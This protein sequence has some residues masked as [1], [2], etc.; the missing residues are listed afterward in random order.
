MKTRS[1]LRSLLVPAAV[2]LLS[3]SVAWAGAGL[4]PVPTLPADP[5]EVPDVNVDDPAT[6]LA[7]ALAGAAATT[8]PETTPF[9]A[10]GQTAMPTTSLADGWYHVGAA[11]VNLYPRPDEYGGVWNRDADACAT[12]DQDAFT[13]VA[14]ELAGGHDGHDHNDHVVTS[15]PWPENP[16]CLYMGGFGIGP[17]NPI[18]EFDDEYGLWV[19]TVV[20]STG[21]DDDGDGATDASVLTVIDAEGWLYDYGSKCD[22]C[23]WKQI[24]ARLADELGVSTSAFV[25]HATHSHASMDFL[26]GWGFVPDWYMQQATDSIEESVRRAVAA[27]EPA[28]IEVGEVLARGQNRERRDTYHAAEDP[29]LSFVRAYVPA[30]T[31]VVPGPAPDDEPV[32][33]KG[34]DYR[35]KAA[36]YYAEGDTEK[37]DKYTAKADEKDAKYGC[38]RADSHEVVVPARTIATIGGYAAHPT[39]KGTNGGVAHPDWP[40]LFAAGAEARFGGMAMHM[41]SGLGNMSSRGGTQIG[42]T[43]AAALPNVGAGDLL[44]ASS[45]RTAETTWAQPATN[46][47]LTGLGLPGFFDRNFLTEPA[48]IQVS[49][50][51]GAKNVAVDPAWLAGQS[52]EGGT[53]SCFSVSPFSVE[54]VARAQNIGGLLAITSGPGEMFSNSTNT[55]EEKALERGAYALAVAQANDSLGYLP[56]SFELSANP[57]A[58]QGGGFVGGGYTYINYEDAYAIDRCFGDANLEFTLTLL[59]IVF[60]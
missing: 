29:T 20:I 55:I 60:S 33:C 6:E 44:Q 26:G 9:L 25:S 43:L 31:Q 36:K 53:S 37:G 57:A 50:E 47:P 28:R 52:P 23:G 42:T 22:D 32:E 45:V 19:R 7:D 21:R 54:I 11:K 56:E 49:E 3:V 27:M 59:G 8:G 46:V 5:T 41:M 2:G 39:T 13:N 35:A 14:P 15:S 10:P 4:A 18:V 34:D 38:D 30:T 40:G 17:V 51:D 24:H 12:L 48:A 1:L 16:D 58:G